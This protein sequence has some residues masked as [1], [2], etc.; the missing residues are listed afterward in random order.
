VNRAVTS[1]FLTAAHKVGVDV[2]FR[3]RCDAK[4]VF[5][6]EFSVLLNVSLGID[7][8]R[9]PRPLTSDEVCVLGEVRI[10]DLTE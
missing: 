5:S 1:E 3:D 6:R 10:E 9:F 2:S 4:V 7:H 8:E